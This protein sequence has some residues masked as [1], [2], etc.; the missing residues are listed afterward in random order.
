MMDA[1]ERRLRCM[2]VENPV[3]LGVGVV[4]SEMLEIMGH[5]VEC[6]S[7]VEQAISRLSAGD[8][9][10]LVLID[11]LQQREVGRAAK[12]AAPSTRVVLATAYSIPKESQEPPSK[13]TDGIDL[14]LCKPVSFEDL[15]RALADFGE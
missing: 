11:G 8:R 15:K 9:F 4:F 7:G 14:I 13:I 3:N 1:H 12:D 2:V 5:T 6:V 10:D